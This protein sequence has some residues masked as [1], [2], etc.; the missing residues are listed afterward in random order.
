MDYESEDRWATLAGNA[1]V[2]STPEWT[3]GDVC[4]SLKWELPTSEADLIHLARTCKRW[5]IR[6]NVENEPFYTRLLSDGELA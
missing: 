3:L 1:A 4:R 6:H 5:G 2:Q